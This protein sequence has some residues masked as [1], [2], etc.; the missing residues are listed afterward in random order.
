MNLLWYVQFANA[1][2]DSNEVEA[3]YRRHSPLRM[4]A[5]RASQHCS[6][7]VIAQGLLSSSTHAMPPQNFDRFKRHTS[8]LDLEGYQITMMHLL[9]AV[10]GQGGGVSLA[11]AFGSSRVASTCACSCWT[12][13]VCK[14]VTAGADLDAVKQSYRRCPCDTMW[15]KLVIV[16]MVARLALKYHPDKAAVRFQQIQAAHEFF[17]KALRQRC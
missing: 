6:V 3:A 10:V 16:G 12:I 5:A 7:K 13:I 2:A 17:K 11:P 8:S 15:L 1:G 9:M 4:S 14:F